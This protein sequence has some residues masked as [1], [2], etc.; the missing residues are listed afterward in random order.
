MCPSA[1]G[2]KIKKGIILECIILLFSS[3]WL[4]R[5]MLVKRKSCLASRAALNLAIHLS[6]FT[7]IIK[8]IIIIKQWRASDWRKQMRLLFVV[9]FPS[10]SSHP[11]KIVGKKCVAIK[12]EVFIVASIEKRVTLF[13]ELS[14]KSF[15][16]YETRLKKHIASKQ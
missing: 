8:K 3:S 7:G 11:S 9:A 14:L 13:S 5:C 16:S 2:V 6:C 10:F 4:G 15:T 1:E 12:R